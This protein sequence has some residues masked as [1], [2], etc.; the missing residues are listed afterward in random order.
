MIKPIKTLFI[1]IL[2]LVG[3]CLGSTA[4]AQ[5]API[6]PGLISQ[7]QAQFGG[8]VVGVQATSLETADIQVLQGDGKVVIV[9]VNQATGQIVNVRR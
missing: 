4:F 8:K 9:T 5:G 2:V 7:I 6:S 3:L 1:S